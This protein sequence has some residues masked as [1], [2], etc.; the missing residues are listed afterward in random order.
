MHNLL[1]THTYISLLYS[2][3]LVHSDGTQIPSKREQDHFYLNQKSLTNITDLIRLVYFQFCIL[4]YIQ[5]N[6]T[7]SASLSSTPSTHVTQYS[8]YYQLWRGW[9]CLVLEAVQVVWRGF[10]VCLLLGEVGV[11]CSGHF[12]NL[13]VVEV[14]FCI[15]QLCQVL[16]VLVLVVLSVAGPWYTIKVLW[17]YN[18]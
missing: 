2:F 11:F 4:L 17:L 1:H 12:P 6:M 13:V 8:R 10:W 9:G 7:Q 18:V 5:Q 14:L 3:L 16:V 15:F